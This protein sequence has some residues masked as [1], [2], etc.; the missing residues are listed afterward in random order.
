MQALLATVGVDQAALDGRSQVPAEFP[1]WF[2]WSH[3]FS[4]LPDPSSPCAASDNLIGSLPTL[5][6]IEISPSK[7]SSPLDRAETLLLYYV[8][9][10]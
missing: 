5:Q 9:V 6:A 1:S 2:L 8:C 4:A 3:P 10:A 7:P